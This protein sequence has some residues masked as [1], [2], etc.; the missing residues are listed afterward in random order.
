M[1]LHLAGGQTPAVFLRALQ[2]PILFNVFVN[3]LDAG[4]ES[5]LSNFADGTKLR[6]AVDSLE[7]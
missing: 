7:G 1:G 4:V 2:G 5:I 6:G 3:D